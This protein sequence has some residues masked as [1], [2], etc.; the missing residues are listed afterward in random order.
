MQPFDV[1]LKPV[2]SEKSLNIRESSSQ[3]T[4]VVKTSATKTDISKA[5][6]KMFDVKTVKIRTCI[7]RVSPKRRGAVTTKSSLV[8]K[9]VITLAPGQKLKLFDVE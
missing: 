3:Y 8:K 1:L 6:A 4:F 7:T 5:I 2:L 9:A